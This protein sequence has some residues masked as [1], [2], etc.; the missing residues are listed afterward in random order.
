MSSNF[1]TR[2]F[3][4]IFRVFF[5]YFKLVRTSVISVIL[6]NAALQLRIIFREH[7]EKGRHFWLRFTK[8]LL[9]IH[10]PPSRVNMIVGLTSSSL[11]KPPMTFSLLKTLGKT[12]TVLQGLLRL[13]P[14]SLHTFCNFKSFENETFQINPKT[15]GFFSPPKRFFYEAD[16]LFVSRYL[17]WSIWKL[18][19]CDGR[20][21]DCRHV[22]VFYKRTVRAHF[23]RKNI[24][25]L[26]QNVK[27]CHWARRRSVQISVLFFAV[28]SRCEISFSLMPEQAVI[29]P[30]LFFK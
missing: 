2:L 21:S 6:Y 10:I 4:G 16:A 19:E 11:T 29:S 25:H 20:L 15:I 23:V 26:L 28:G 22:E 3:C 1:L 9:K 27:I 7:L 18:T 8:T 14:S 13:S 5:L 17:F 30:A 24:I 12:A